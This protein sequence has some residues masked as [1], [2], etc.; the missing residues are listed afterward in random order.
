MGTS[1]PLQC[2]E[3]YELML[4]HRG[5]RVTLAIHNCRKPTIAAMN[6]AAVGIG[7]TMTLPMAIR[8]A[9]SAAK[10]GFVFGRR[11]LV[12]EAASSFFL[13]KLI[14]LSQAMHL[15]TTGATYPAS[16]KLLS[17]LFSETV[18]NP[19]DVLPRALEIAQEF[20][21]NCSGVS[22]ALMRDMMWRNP[23]S[24]EGAHLL[25]SRII[26][27]LFSTPDNKEG[28]KSFLEKRKVHFQGN[29]E[30]DAP[31]AYVSSAFPLDTTVLAC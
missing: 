18:D 23:G 22:W 21:E 7:I 24:A 14:G 20:T 16:H 6:G 9:P 3:M 10:I 25:D 13:P 8:I 11:G 12:M 2:D 26:Y 31:Q 17:G 15:I 5:G 4:C 29:I 19:A 30:R 28:V 27:D 1:L